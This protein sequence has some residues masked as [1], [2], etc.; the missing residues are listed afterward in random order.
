MTDNRRTRLTAYIVTTVWST[1]L[2]LNGIHLSDTWSRFLSF[3]P[4]V[5]VGLFALFDNWLWQIKPLRRL[6][7]RPQ[8]NGTWKGELTSIRADAD[9]KEVN[10]DPIPVFIVIRQSFLGL[11]IMLLSEET[12]SRSIGALLQ[13]T[14]PA[15]FC[16]Y[17]HYDSKPHIRVRTKSPRHA[18]GSK[19]EVSGIEPKRLSGEYWTDRQTRG[20]FE[21]SKASSAKVGTWVEA[22]EAVEAEK[23]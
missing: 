17:Y 11:S 6:F 15:G 3:F 9:G 19:I 22:N 10:H 14:P 8:L 4:L 13:Y 20:S 2:A 7:N 18:G 1:V 5:L 16:I 21:V 12:T 23:D